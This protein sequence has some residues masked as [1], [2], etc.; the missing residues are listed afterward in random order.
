MAPTRRPVNREPT[1]TITTATTTTMGINLKLIPAP[2]IHPPAAIRITT[3]IPHR[4]AADIMA[5]STA[6][7]GIT[8]AAGISAV[9]AGITDPWS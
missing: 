4:L 7:A 8:A 1:I 3:L 5:V 9:V 2:R 6:V